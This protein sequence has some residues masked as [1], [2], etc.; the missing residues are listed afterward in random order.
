M[1]H[2][3]RLAS[4]SSLCRVTSE[5]TGKNPFTPASRE[6]ST[7]KTPK[8]RTDS[9]KFELF[10]SEAVKPLGSAWVVTGNPFL[11]VELTDMGLIEA[12]GLWTEPLLPESAEAITD[13]FLRLLKV[14]DEPEPFI[15]TET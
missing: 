8:A 4:A 13:T 11:Q 15:Q 10:G 9:Q 14:L 5:L 12:S 2:G 7:G 3:V 1:C 6:A